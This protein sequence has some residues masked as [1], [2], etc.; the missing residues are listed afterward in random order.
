MDALNQDGGGSTTMLL[1]E[2]TRPVNGLTDLPAPGVERRVYDSVYV[3]TGGVP[4]VS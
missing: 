4:V 1:G 2:G 3:A